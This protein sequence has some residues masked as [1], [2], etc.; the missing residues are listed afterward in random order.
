MKKL[1]LSFHDFANTEVLTREQLKKISGGL[2]SGC[3]AHT[4][5]WTNYQ[6]GYS[7]GSEAQ[8]SASNYATQ[9]NTQ[10]FYC[11]NCENSQ[12]Y[13]GSGAPNQP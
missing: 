10:T 7:N 3:C 8:Q 9:N 11:C 6:C 5:N 4:A 13:P 1:K 12:G 2:T